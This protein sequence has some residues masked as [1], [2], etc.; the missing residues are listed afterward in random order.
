MKATIASVASAMYDNMERKERTDGKPYY[1]LKE[2]ESWQS[3]IIH[4]AHLDRMPSDDIYERINDVL[5]TLADLDNDATEDSATERFYEIEPDVYTS[6][7]TAWLNS[8]NRNVYYLVEAQESGVT[9]GFQLLAIAQQKYI[10]EIA[11]AV[12]NG[13]VKYV[14]EIKEDDAVRICDECGEIMTEGFCISGGEEYYCSEPCRDKNYT[15]EEWEVLY[16]N[17]NGDSYFT[18]W[19]E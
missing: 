8:D 18:T 14:E 17:G 7:L 10:M 1:V 19:D 9:D 12:L 16:D 15:E 11:Y 6:D 4:N 5:S 3:D 13:I 2:A